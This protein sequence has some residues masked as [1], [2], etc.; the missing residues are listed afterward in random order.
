M[1]R[2]RIRIRI[3]WE[4]GM[5]TDGDD[6]E[7]EPVQ[8]ALLALELSAD[9]A[10]LLGRDALVRDGRVEHVHRRRADVDPDNGLRVRREFSR[11]QAYE[12]HS[13]G[14]ISCSCHPCRGETAARTDIARKVHEDGGVLVERIMRADRLRGP[15]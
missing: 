11:R 13:V 8:L 14:S 9:G 3:R 15:I 4:D 5:E 6:I 10:H 12:T 2:V 7:R 1:G